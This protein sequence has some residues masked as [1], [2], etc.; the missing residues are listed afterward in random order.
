MMDDSL[1]DLIDYIV[2]V[3]HRY[4]RPFIQFWFLLENWAYWIVN[5]VFIKYK[6]VP[7]IENRLLLLPAT[8]L[9]QKIRKREVLI[10]TILVFTYLT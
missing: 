9:T 8:K 3:A 4:I 6:R 2:R 5:A 7:K 1:F 10:S